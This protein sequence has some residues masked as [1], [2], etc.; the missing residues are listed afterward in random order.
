[1]KRLVCIT[2][3]LIIHNLSYSQTV[4]WAFGFG[5]WVDDTVDGMTTDIHGAVY[6]IGEAPARTII[7]EHTFDTGGIFVAK[8]NNEGAPIWV[9]NFGAFD[10]RGSDLVV[11][12]GG[13]VYITG[14]Y[15]DRFEIDHISVPSGRPTMYLMK[16]DQNGGLVWLKDFVEYPTSS[17]TFGNAITLDDDGNIY[18]AGLLESKLTVGDSTY[19]VRGNSGYPD[20]LLIKFSSD[21]DVIFVKNPG[22]RSYDYFY[23]IAV[24][25][26]GIYGVGTLGS[27]QT[28]FDNFIHTTDKSWQGVLFHYSLDGEFRWA[29]SFETYYSE[30]YSVEINDKNEIFVNGLWVEDNTDE[31]KYFFVSKLDSAGETL[32]TRLLFRGQSPCCNGLSLGKKSDIAINATNVFMT[33]GIRWASKVD[34]FSFE[35]TGSTEVGVI[36][37]NE[38]GY[39]QWLYHTANPGNDRGLRI[40]TTDEKIYISGTF[41]SKEFTIGNS[42]ITNNSGNNDTDVFIA[43]MTDSPSQLCPDTDYSLSYETTFCDGDSIQVSIDNPYA[44]YTTWAKD[45]QPLSFDN[46]KRV[47][48]KEPGIYEVEI[49]KNTVCPGPTLSIVIN[50]E[51]HATQDT[52]VIIHPIPIFN[53]EGT[54]GEFCQRDTMNLSTTFHSDYNY[55][56]LVPEGYST[57]DPTQNTIKIGMS[58]PSEGE[59]VFLHVTYKNTGCSAIDSI[60]FS[61]Q[62][63]AEARIYTP[64]FGIC[65]GDQVHIQAQSGLNYQ[66]TWEIPDFFPTINKSASSIAFT[67]TD[68]M[69]GAKLVVN[70]NEFG[71]DCITKDSIYLNVNPPFD[72]DI[73]V[74]EESL[75]VISDE[76]L[77]IYWY[78]ENQLLPASTN[79]KTLLIEE[80]GDYSVFAY[81]ENGCRATFNISQA[82]I[83][84]IEENTSGV[85]L[86]PNPVSDIVKFQSAEIP[87][88]IYLYDLEG[89][90]LL[91]KAYTKEIDVSKLKVGIYLIEV[92]LGNKSRRLRIIKE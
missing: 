66:Y 15:A 43:K 40:N 75:N 46:K 18:L 71:G 37:L 58:T 56:W 80:P 39:P 8:F 38:I 57:T 7:D 13:N 91:Q 61:V 33:T 31:G 17:R 87:K 45:G 25:S 30:A 41:A 86:Y 69:D 74:D 24:S 16:L 73:K 4:D 34:P 60:S 70:V 62:Q 55:N 64:N 59:K 12:S 28:E 47:Y 63:S 81:N 89:Q 23:D 27:N 53:I 35:E 51:S 6:I 3:L 68:Q 42:T 90:L 50:D 49:N 52:D 72:I 26:S 82:T 85:Y 88:R 9:R 36:K 19:E 21:G 44:V 32:Y 1:M 79:S 14:Y 5:G 29:K 67:A 22:S 11:D 76:A 2:I 78:L 65:E 84:N 77:E 54:V 83:M 10:C 92:D 20:M 48:L